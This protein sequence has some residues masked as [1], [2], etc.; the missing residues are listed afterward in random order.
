[1]LLLVVLLSPDQLTAREIHTHNLKHQCQGWQEGPITFLPTY[2]YHL[3][4]N[5]YSGDPV[6]ASLIA[7]VKAVDSYSSLADSSNSNSNEYG[8]AGSSS[9]LAAGAEGR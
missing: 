3:G 6:P 4:C 5:V 2:K 8:A 7:S 9:I 1:M